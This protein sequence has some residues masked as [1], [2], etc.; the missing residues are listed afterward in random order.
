M[1][2]IR[3]LAAKIHNLFSTG[4][5]QNR[6]DEDGR[7]QVATHTGRVLEKTEAFPYG[8]T[9][10]AKSGRVLVFCQGGNYNGFEILPVLKADDVA[11]PELEAGDAALYTGGR[12]LC[13]CPRGGR[14]GSPCGRKRR[15]FG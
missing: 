2:G 7:V 15:G 9:A 11:A 4:E 6:Y 13:H 8:F 3:E 10:K 12:R 14:C 5:F 1:T